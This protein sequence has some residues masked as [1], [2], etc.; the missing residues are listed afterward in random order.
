[1]QLPA[2]KQYLESS[3]EQ[4]EQLVKD[5][6]GLFAEIE[7]GNSRLTE[8]QQRTAGKK[9]MESQKWC[10]DYRIKNLEQHTSG[11][12]QQ[13]GT[14]NA[15]L[16]VIAGFKDDLFHK[17]KGLQQ[18]AKEAAQLQVLSE[19]FSQDGIPYQIIRD[20]VPEL[21]AAANEILGRMTSG[22]MRLEFVTE[23]V[24]KSNKAKEIATLEII[25]IDVDNGVLPYL[26]RSGG[27]KVRAA[28]AN[29][30]AL[31]MIKASR[32][33]LQLG[34]LFIDEPSFLDADGIEG[35]CAALETIH[36]RY[37]DMRILAI[38]HDE[39]MKS[40]FPQQLYV[41]VTENGSR[42]RRL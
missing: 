12:N 6:E 38:S 15:K 1:M 33:G 24:L 20:I 35:Y 11:L 10:A 28:L 26:S 18:A 36:N 2:A 7:K 19:A 30:F 31:A 25:I 37:P 17:N 9:D 3:R 8:L 4:I 42:V 13:I 32:V 34:M 41:D 22:R 14:I 27:Q 39:N 5:L 21:E 23:K 16:E 40:R 29:S